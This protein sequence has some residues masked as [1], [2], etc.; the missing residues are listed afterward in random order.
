MSDLMSNLN[1]SEEE[2]EEPKI[3]SEDITNEFE[4]PPDPKEWDEVV[5]EDIIV[6]FVGLVD[7]KSFSSVPTS[8]VKFV[9]LLD[10]NKPLLQLDRL[11]FVGK[12]E[13]VVG[14]DV[15]FEVDDGE[16]WSTDDE[17]FNEVEATTKKTNHKLHFET[18]TNKKLIMHQA[19]LSSIK[20]D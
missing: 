2:D 11:L 13:N 9:G 10:S 6:E 4:E 3:Q 20:K 12:R 5:V 8:K 19:F 18:K 14:T 15:V 16:Q 17:E 7:E 1:S